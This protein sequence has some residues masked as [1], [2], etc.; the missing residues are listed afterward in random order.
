M[1]MKNYL[2]NNFNIKKLA[3][4]LDEVPFWSAPFGLKLLNYVDY[5]RNISALDIGF[6]TGFPLTELAMRLGVSSTVYGIDPWKIAQERT[7]KK[8]NL[9]G[10]PNIKIIDAS[11]ESIPL[12]NGSIDLITSNNGINNISDIEK[13]ISECSR[14]I[15][16]GGQ[17]IQ[18]MNTDKTMIEFYDELREVLN[19]LKLF[20]E[21]Q[22]MERHIYEKRRPVDEIISILKRYNF[23]VQNI[24]QDE[25]CYKFADGTAM[26]NHFFIKLAFMDSWIEILPPDKTEMIFDEVEKRMNKLAEANG[27]FKLTI[28]FVTINAI[29]IRNVESMSIN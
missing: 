29:K 22:S 13:V 27:Y 10:I 17:F 9:W 15:K 7:K 26:L 14:I 25:F 20:G 6:G 24:E 3:D 4:V 23:S 18:T 19:D 21:I 8:I 11:A 5:R 28:P 12:E 1:V 16:P 2:Q